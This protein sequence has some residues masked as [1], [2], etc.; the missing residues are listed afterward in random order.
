M[1]GKFFTSFR[2]KSMTFSSII[3][4]M[5]FVFFT[6]WGVRNN[7]Y[8]SCSKTIK[9]SLLLKLEKFFLK[10]F[11]IMALV[12][13]FFSNTRVQKH[14]RIKTH[15]GMSESLRLRLRSHSLMWTTC[16]YWKFFSFGSLICEYF[17]GRTAWHGVTSL[18]RTL[19]IQDTS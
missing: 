14:F 6:F 9:A 15:L 17:R 13:T 11:I 12:K 1:N 18:C 10:L 7:R 4:A 2:E 16:D 19:V 3:E 5:T 8:A